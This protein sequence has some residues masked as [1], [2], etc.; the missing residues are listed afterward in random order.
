MAGD[1]YLVTKHEKVHPYPRKD[2]D[3]AFA[4]HFKSCHLFN[5]ADALLG[6][7]RAE[8]RHLARGVGVA[9]ESGPTSPLAGTWCGACLAGGLVAGQQAPGQPHSMRRP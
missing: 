9:G 1:K 7:P 5:M 8:R 3:V 4:I 6:R 2:G